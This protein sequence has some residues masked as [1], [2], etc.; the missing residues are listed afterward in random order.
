MTETI[1]TIVTLRLNRSASYKRHAVKTWIF[2][3]VLCI[4]IETVL[5]PSNAGCVP[6]IEVDQC[7][8]TPPVL[9]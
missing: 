7:Y 2:E 5:L 4:K 1:D 9:P 8:Q 3:D 6:K